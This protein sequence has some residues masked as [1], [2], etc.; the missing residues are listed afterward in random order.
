VQKGGAVAKV[1][2][3]PVRIEYAYDFKPAEMRRLR[4]ITIEHETLFLE[5]WNEYFSR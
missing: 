4:E 2:L 3:R 1:W 5:R